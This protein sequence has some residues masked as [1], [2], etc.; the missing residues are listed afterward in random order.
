M[1]EQQIMVMMVMMIQNITMATTK[2]TSQHHLL[3]VTVNPKD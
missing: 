1:S 3:Q 2:L